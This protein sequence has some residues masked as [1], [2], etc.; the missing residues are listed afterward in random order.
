MQFTYAIERGLNVFMEKPV[1]VDGPSSRRMFALGEESVKKNLK[2]GVG[3]CAVTA[4]LAVNST[5]RFRTADRRPRPAACLPPGGSHRLRRRGSQAEGMNE[6]EYQIRNF[7]AFLW[8]SGGGYS[9][10]LIHNID[11]CC[12]MKGAWP[13]E[14]RGAGGRHYRE[15]YVDQNFDSYST[16][17][18]FADGSKLMLEGRTMS[19]C[20]QEFASLAHGS[21]GS[22]VISQAG[23]A[24][25][26]ARAFKGQ[27]MHK[28]DIVWQW[29]TQ[30][31]SPYQLEWNHL[32]DAIRNDKPYNEVKRG[33]EASLTTA[34]GRMAC[35][36]G[37]KV[38]WEDALNHTR[39][40]PRTP[41]SS[42]STD[43]RRS[44]PTPKAS[45]PSPCRASSPRR[46]T[47]S[48]DEGTAL[49]PG[50]SCRSERRTSAPVGRWP[51]R[52]D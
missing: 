39:S 31:P 23:H 22:A 25:S 6:L 36:T 30:E 38:T 51:E 26:K 24:P 28:D 10:F 32:I 49:D 47:T 35:H 42:A 37:Q 16:E 4:M 11:E 52:G 27:R 9:D 34:M 40:S 29:G 48:P 14:A 46:N 45:T 13:V 18:T 33:V 20:Y 41:T 2:V 43:P 7:H 8:A 21:K 12:W 5:A 3:S 1:T 17:F 50:S 44:W 15:K 19:G